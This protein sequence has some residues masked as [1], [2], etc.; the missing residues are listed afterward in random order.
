[1]V[2]KRIGAIVR[3]IDFAHQA[4]MRDG[5]VVAL[6]IVVDV[7][8][9][10]A[11]DDVVAAFGE[12]QSGKLKAAR[13]FG[14]SSEIRGKAFGT[15]LTRRRIEIHKDEFFLRF[16]AHRNHAHGAAIEEFDTVNVGCA[17]QFS[18]EGVS[19]TVVLAAHD[20]LAAAAESDWS[21]AM[22][23]HVAE[24]AERSLLVAHDEQRLGFDIG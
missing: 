10:I 1:M 18:V 12:L 7:D 20:V 4:G 9:P 21:R 16:E 23:A 8:L 14:N 11:I 6:E 13:L 2:A 3:V 24:G 15:L 17:D 19:P 22:A 5:N